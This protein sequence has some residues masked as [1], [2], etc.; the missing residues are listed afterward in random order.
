MYHSLTLLL[1]HGFLDISKHG[2]VSK[3]ERRRWNHLEAETNC[4]LALLN[5]CFY[6]VAISC[7]YSTVFYFV[8]HSD[9]RRFNA[10]LVKSWFWIIKGRS[11]CSIFILI[12]L[13]I[14]QSNPAWPVCN[15]GCSETVKYSWNSQ[16]LQEKMD[17]FSLDHFTEED[18][19]SVL[20]VNWNRFFTNSS[21]DP[22]QKRFKTTGR[23]VLLSEP[24]SILK[25][26]K[27]YSQK[28]LLSVDG[29]QSSFQTVCK[30]SKTA[31]PDCP[32]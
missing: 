1:A 6:F 9:G 21:Q 24:Q 4:F 13:V 2:S 15:N 29:T 26:P 31:P 23:L 14:T 19:I 12:F 10:F 17:F 25:P 16:S 5:P 8:W 30:F 18:Q 20:R 7:S 28:G 27:N 11:T 32:I 22:P 3:R